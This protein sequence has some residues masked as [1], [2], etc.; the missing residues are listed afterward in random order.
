MNSQ[1]IHCIYMIESF[2]KYFKRVNDNKILTLGG[3][4]NYNL[5]FRFRSL[6]LG[7]SKVFINHKWINFLFRD[8]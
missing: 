2:S 4:L 7:Y 8:N 1:N 3:L 6:K 5:K